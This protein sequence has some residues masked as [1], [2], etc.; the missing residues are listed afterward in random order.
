VNILIT[1]ATSAQAH[2]LK[3]EL[4]NDTVLLGDHFEMPRFMLASG[5]MIR[6]PNPSSSSY[7]HEM[8]ALCLDKQ[9][10]TVYIF[11]DEE[12]KLLTEAEQLFKEY[13]ISLITT[14]EV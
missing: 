3:S 14:N 4:K 9:V 2:R 10:D 6:L 7:T 1:A 13:G 8:L 12:I 5:A 11:R